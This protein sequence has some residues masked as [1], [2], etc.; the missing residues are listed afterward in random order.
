MMTGFLRFQDALRQRLQ[1]FVRRLHPRIDAG[2]AAEFD[3]GFGIED[4]AG[5]RDE[6]RPG[7]RRGRDLGG[8]AHDARQILQPRHL[9]RPFHQ[10]LRHLDQRAVE[11]RLHQPVA[12]LLLAGGED[13]R[14]A[15]EFGVE[16]RAHRVAEPGRDMDIAGDQFSGGAAVTVGDGD[17]QAFLHRHHIGEIGMVLQRMHDRQ[18]GGAGIAEQ[19]GNALVLEQGQ[20]RRAPGDAIYSI[21]LLLP[22]AVGLRVSASWPIRTDERNG[23]RS[24]LPCV[25]GLDIALPAQNIPSCS[26]CFFFFERCQTT[27]GKPFSGTSG[28][29]VQV[30]SCNC[31]IAM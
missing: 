26:T 19:M 10:R 2:G 13:H 24:W 18:F 25:A 9:D 30:H 3:A 21:R 5:Q 6:H 22:A 12:L 4:I 17:H 14:R 8:A 7:R 11:H 23:A 28:S 31:S 29:P 20:K 16:Q 27:P 1:R 15:G